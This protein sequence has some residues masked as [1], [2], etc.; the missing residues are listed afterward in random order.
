[1]L[2]LTFK[3]TI[4]GHD[5]RFEQV[6]LE[7]NEP[8]FFITSTQLSFFMYKHSSGKWLILYHNLLDKEL[9]KLESEFSATLGER[10][11]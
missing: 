3:K 5:F 6:L 1:M 8:L 9:L 2:G 4:G 10:G 11:Y 7:N